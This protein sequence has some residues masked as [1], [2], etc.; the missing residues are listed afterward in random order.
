MWETLLPAAHIYLTVLSGAWAS[1][2]CWF[3]YA[4]ISMGFV[5]LGTKRCWIAGME[6]RS[7]DRLFQSWWSTWG[8]YYKPMSVRYMKCILWLLKPPAKPCL[9]HQPQWSP[10]AGHCPL[11]PSGTFFHSSHFWQEVGATCRG[12]WLGR[13]RITEVC[14]GNQKPPCPASKGFP[15]PHRCG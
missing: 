9:S 3:F 8:T 13:G 5:L 1:N 2:R 4:D 10:M 12:E 6:I 7:R 14:C 15:W 11:E